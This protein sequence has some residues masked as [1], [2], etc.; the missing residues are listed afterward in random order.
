[1]PPLGYPVQQAAAM[2]HPEVMQLPDRGAHDSGSFT[3]NDSPFGTPR[4][5]TSDSPYIAYP[6]HLR[7]GMTFIHNDPA[8]YSTEYTPDQPR[9]YNNL[10]YSG[11][12]AMLTSYPPSTFFH[13]P[14][15]IYNTPSLPD[16]S[17]SEF[18]HFDDEENVHYNH[19]I[20]Q[21]RQFDYSS[22]WSDASRS[23]TPYRV[24]PM[25][26]VA[27]DKDQPYA[28][29]IYHALLHAPNHTMILKDIYEW[30]ERFTNKASHSTTKGWQNSIRHN[31][32]MNGVST[33]PSNTPSPARFPLDQSLHPTLPPPVHH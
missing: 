30:F 20:K 16:T 29:L 24:D 27:L 9:I 22:T 21:E 32:S 15:N 28:Q 33:F 31:L 23:P 26:D 3:P 14:P 13:T 19:H 6:Q 17:M 12:S 25:E 4:S 18:M 7:P 11:T 5:Y 10:D 2:L 8:R 1:M